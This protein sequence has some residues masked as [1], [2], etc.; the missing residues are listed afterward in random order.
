MGIGRASRITL[1]VAA[2]TL[3][4]GQAMGQATDDQLFTVEVPVVLTMTA[5]ADAEITHDTT[6]ANQAFPAGTWTVECNG[7][8]GATATFATATVFTHTTD[9]AYKR[10]VKLSLALGTADTGSGWAVTTPTDQTDRANTDPVAQVVAAS[11]AAGNATLNLTVEFVDNS[12]STLA[13]GDY[14]TT[15]TGTLTAN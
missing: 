7:V 12:Y 2:L 10:D 15:V 1:A 8:D 9:N 6:N 13:A 3:F 11:T 4:A 14:T 5:P